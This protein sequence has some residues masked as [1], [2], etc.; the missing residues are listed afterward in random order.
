MQLIDA[1]CHFDFPRFDQVRDEEFGRARQEGLT[2]M[3]IPGVR[4]QD[5][6]R[7]QGLASPEGGIWYCLGVHP[8]F[9]PEHSEQ[10]LQALEEA[11]SAHPRGCVGL[12][13]CGLDA[14]QGDMAEQV[15]WFRAQVGIASR[16][17]LPLVI[18]S[19]KSHDQV[20]ATL[21]SLNWSGRALVH[22]FSGSYPQAKKLVDL[23][24][25]IGVG[26]VITYDRAQK[27][28]DAIARLPLEALVLETDAPDMAPA[29]VAKGMNSPACLPLIMRAL[30]ELR[31]DSPER[32]APT[33]FNNACALYGWPE[34]Q[35][36]S[37]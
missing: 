22:G 21:R 28:R 29:G 19:V 9:V 31:G 1:H 30:A 32:L 15:E 6:A 10:D 26:G 4:R 36:V 18:H 3:V 5:W 20:H 7:V 16:L 8:W 2:A 17:S 12:G 14:L 24:C 35:G 25:Y 37:E 13:E 27:T 11:L 34:A 33:L 23:G